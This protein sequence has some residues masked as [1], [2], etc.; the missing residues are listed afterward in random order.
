[1]SAEHRG[2]IGAKLRYQLWQF[3]MMPRYDNCTV[4]RPLSEPPHQ[5]PDMSI[6]DRLLNGH[7]R[8]ATERF[9]CQP[10]PITCTT[11]G[12]CDQ[13]VD[14]KCLFAKSERAKVACIGACAHLAC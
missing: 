1:M 6:S 9:E 13:R 3:A 8:N 12:G 2:R 10:R 7:P 14:A 11:V 5:G 4:R